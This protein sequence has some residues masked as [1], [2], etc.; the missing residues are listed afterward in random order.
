MN[1]LSLNGS[2]SAFQVGGN[3]CVPAVVPG[4]VHTALLEA[5]KISDPF[6]R[7][8]E[9][10]SFW[11]GDVAWSFSRT[12]SVTASVL[13]KDHVLLRCLGLDTLAT[14][15]LNGK[16]LGKTDNMHRT[17]EFDVKGILR[18]GENSI[19]IRFDSATKYTEAK[20]RVRSIPKWGVGDQRGHHNYIR[21][22]ACNFG[23]DWG[24]QA[25]TCG[26]W[27]DIEIAAFDTARLGDVQ[28]IQDHSVKKRTGLSVAVAAEVASRG[29]LMAEVQVKL[30]GKVVAETSQP[31]RGGKGKAQLIIKNPE[32][33]WP[34][35][36]GKQPRYDVKVT[37]RNGEGA[38]LDTWSKKIGLRTLVLD[39]QDDEWGES[40]QFVVNGVPFFSKGAN[41]IPADAFYDQAPVERVRD[42]LQSAVDA[43]MN[44]LRVW[45]GGYYEEDSFYDL[46]DERGICVW[47][48]FMFACA[49]YPSFDEDFLEN[50]RSEA[51]D[52]IKR[53]RHHAC[54]AVWCGNNELE[55]GLWDD[56]WTDSAMGIEDYQRLFD[57]L[58]PKLVKD[59]DGVTAY[60]PGS[61][62]SSTGDRRDYNNPACGD[63]HLW[64]VWH[65]AEPFEWY[66]TCDHRFNS[67]FGFQSFPEPKTAHSFTEPRDR[68]VTSYIMEQHQRNGT[69]NS[70]IMDHMLSWFRLPTGF[71]ETLWTSQI[72]QG[73]A[74]KYACEH[75]RRSMP[76]GMGTLY[77]QLND[78]WPVA[79]WS[80]IDYYHRWKALHY[81]AKKFYA[82]LLLSGVEDKEKGTVDI[83][84]THDG[85]KARELTL[86]WFV[87]DASGKLI[88]EGKKAV[89]AG[90]NA[91][92][93]VHTL[94]L[95]KIL[96][97]KTA[98]NCIVWLEVY[99]GRRRVGENM[100][101]FA[102]PKHLELGAKPKIKA[103]VKAGKGGRFHVTLT[104]TSAAL[105]TW[106]ELKNA[107]FRADDN[108]V[109]LRPGSALTLTVTPGSELTLGQFRSQLMVKSLVDLS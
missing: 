92:R 73:M 6:Y 78:C 27:R 31:L 101:L 82:P 45:G 83:H 100:V 66:R 94:R 61:P 22:E 85:L 38:M 11:V 3:I 107:E 34:V 49:T 98:R 5:G 60:W 52:N 97:E 76:R 68:N 15:R 88:E 105:W 8:Q 74:I 26:I 12:F 20:N 86:K 47:Q 93:R 56:E 30:R 28:V 72:L 36:M 109:H 70:K 46:C 99:Q 108:F 95:K 35:N 102:R 1:T 42:L 58:L 16:T 44:M 19:E 24:I 7:D 9:F 10:D 71:D 96:A 106:I 80:S 65:G 33:W 29:K 40:F 41:W 17:W 51:I 21:K 67:E 89:K 37:L 48:D 14:V 39:R 4:C 32:L 87:T 84:L 2:W 62:H 50:V 75:W 54:L 55:Q 103:A 23:W 69:G 43:N 77:W 53:I 91:N 25:V 79:S 59:Y 63:A 18:D 104:S 81:M 90:A 13:A 64:S 57:D